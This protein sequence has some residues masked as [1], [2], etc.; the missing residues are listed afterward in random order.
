MLGTPVGV[1]GEDGVDLG[2]PN[3][4]A[5]HYVGMLMLYALLENDGAL[6]S[7]PF[8]ISVSA[9]ATRLAVSRVHI[10]KLLADTDSHG[11]LVWQRDTREVPLQPRLVS[12]AVTYF[13]IVFLLFRSYRALLSAADEPELLRA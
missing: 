1:P 11:L 12:A 6:E 4:F 9:I 2:I 5:E 10:L 3:V 7:Q 8:K 13:C